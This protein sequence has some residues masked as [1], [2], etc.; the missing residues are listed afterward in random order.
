M[1]TNATI[2]IGVNVTTGNSLTAMVAAESLRIAAKQQGV[3]LEEAGIV[4]SA[5]SV[6]RLAAKSLATTCRRLTLFGN[7]NN[8]APRVKLEAMAGEIYEDAIER[9]ERGETS[10]VGIELAP[11]FPRLLKFYKTLDRSAADARV[12]L[13]AEVEAAFGALAHK[14]PPLTTTIDLHG[15][16]RRLQFVITATSQSKAFIAESFLMPGATVCDAARPADV[17]ERLRDSRPDVFVYEGGLVKLPQSRMFGLTNIIDCEPDVNLACL[18]ETMVL[19]MSGIRRDY[20]LGVS[21]SLEDADAVMRLALSHGFAPYCPA[22]DPRPSNL[23]HN[24]AERRE[25]LAG[26]LQSLH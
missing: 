18:S 17:H 21:P 25:A 7:P 14:Q 22:R 5:G 3:E 4:G 23:R 2:V 15:H 9:A 20:S 16:M 11:V 13:N 10:G 24:S 26:P 6:G 8:P 12:R 19:A 1:T